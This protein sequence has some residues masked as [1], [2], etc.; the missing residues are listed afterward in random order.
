M[1][2]QIEQDV[3]ECLNCKHYGRTPID[4]MPYCGMYR[5]TI[6]N[7]RYESGILRKRE[8]C[9]YYEFIGKKPE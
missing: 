8:Y 6:Y 5:V 3:K 9:S 4:K 2:I 1:G 7:L